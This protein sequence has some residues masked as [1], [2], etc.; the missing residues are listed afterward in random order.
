MKSISK[1]RLI[2]FAVSSIVEILMVILGLIVLAYTLQLADIGVE[3]NILADSLNNNIELSYTGKVQLSEGFKHRLNKLKDNPLI[4]HNKYKMLDAKIGEL[5][6]LKNRRALLDHSY[7]IRKLLEESREKSRF[8][9]A[10]II[11][12]SAFLFLIVYIFIIFLPDKRFQKSIDNITQSLSKLETGRYLKLEETVFKETFQLVEQ[13]KRVINKT[14][15]V[16]RMKTMLSAINEIIIKS[17]TESQI[18]SDVCKVL[19]QQG[20]SKLAW[21]GI[22]NEGGDITKTYFCGDESFVKYIAGVLNS[23]FCSCPSAKR[24]ERGRIF[25]NN[26][27]NANKNMDSCRDEML[28]RNYLSSASMPIIKKGRLIATLNIYVDRINFFKKKNFDQLREGSD[29][30]SFA[31]DKMADDKWHNIIVE[32]LK[33]LSYSVIIDTNLTIV[34]ANQAAEN[35]LSE[36]SAGKLLGRNCSIFNEKLKNIILT[37]DLFDNIKKDKPFNDLLTYLRKDGNLSYLDTVITY[38]EAAEGDNYFIISGKDITKEVNLRDSVNK[39]LFYDSETDLPN[40]NHFLESA[41]AY[42]MTAENKQSALAIIDPHNFTYINNTIGFING[43]KLLKSIGSRLTGVLKSGDLVAKAPASRFYLFIKDID[44]KYDLSSILKRI[45]DEL[46]RP[47]NIDSEE[48]KV[49]FHTGISI[50]PNDAENASDLLSKAETALLYSKQ[51]GDEESI[52]QPSFFTRKIALNI[53]RIEKLK[54]DL[55]LAIKQKEFVLYYQ[56]YFNPVSKAVT[57]AESLLRWQKDGKIIMPGAFI[58][59]LEKS[60]MIRDVEKWIINQACSDIRKRQ[61][62]G[63]K[64]VPISINI[65]PNSFVAPDLTSNILSTLEK[66]RVN[67]ALLTIEITERLFMSN[68]SGAKKIL[69]NLKKEGIKISMDDFGTGYSSLSYLEELPI[70]ILKIDISFVRKMTENKRSISIT[71]SIIAVAKALSLSTIAEGVETEGQ[72]NILTKL[73]CDNIQGWIFAKAMSEDQFE[74]VLSK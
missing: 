47:F 27:I 39:M 35:I 24:A 26:N 3:F 18:F 15:N 54:D 23:T 61:D 31:L 38:F 14:I 73:K 72:L 6:H 30:I 17:K 5:L 33:D 43:S 56:P 60:A 28:K 4:S 74:M 59:V 32:A 12:I 69:N 10:A 51:S 21:I 1:Q 49:L 7:G 22:L 20:K 67:P 46:K 68:L 71:K 63:L 36:D 11:A 16:I 58:H 57:G 40:R 37:K 29:V 64:I 50:Y 41:E 42:I 34:Y 66:Y 53:K 13:S 44:T 25:I 48:I 62:K 9:L 55:S 70:D 45:G 2:G 19:V 52:N 65:S 8:I